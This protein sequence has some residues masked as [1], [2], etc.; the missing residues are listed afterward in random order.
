MQSNARGNVAIRL[1]LHAILGAATGA[2]AAG[3]ILN[4][5][6]GNVPGNR[7]SWEFYLYPGLIFGLAFGIAFWFRGRLTLVGATAFAAAAT[8][9][10]ALAV[11][12][13]TAI[14]DPAGALLGAEATSDRVFCVTGAIAG[15]IGGGL[16]GYGTGRLL[17]AAGWPRL[18]AAG[19][20]LGLLLPLVQSEAGFFAFFSLWQAGYAA[21]MATLKRI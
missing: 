18:L 6:L 17:G 10:N 7:L 21:T 5:P 9:S 12:A 13:W 19:A 11:L 15:A 3:G 14:D 16:L 20:A 4:L 8:V 1:A 2:V